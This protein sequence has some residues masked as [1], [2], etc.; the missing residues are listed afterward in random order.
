[1]KLKEG[2]IIEHKKK[3][4]VGEIPDAIF[5]EIYG[6]KSDE[7]KN[8]KQIAK[9]REKFKFVESKKPKSQTK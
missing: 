2:V 6:D 3:R 5:E 8:K 4:Y 1:M 9:A 7:D